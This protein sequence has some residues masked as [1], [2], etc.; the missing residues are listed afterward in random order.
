MSD[1]KLTQEKTAKDKKREL[2]LSQKA[3]LDAFLA[4]GA[5][6]KAQYDKSYGCLKEKM[7]FDDP[8]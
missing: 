8:E 5:I 2:F 7:G 1:E 6:T 4:R 3:T